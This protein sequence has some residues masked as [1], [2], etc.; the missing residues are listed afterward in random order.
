MK[1]FALT[2]LG[3]LLAISMAGCSHKDSPSTQ[4]GGD[5]TTQNAESRDQSQTSGQTSDQS[6]DNEGGKSDSSTEAKNQNTSKSSN[7]PSKPEAVIQ[8]L[9]QAVHVKFNKMAPAHVPMSS[10]MFLTG[11]TKASPYHYDVHF[12]QTSKPTPINSPALNHVDPANDLGIVSGTYYANAD[13]AAKQISIESFGANKPNV[14]LG[15]GIK[16]LSD[17]GAGHSYLTWNEG[18]WQIQIN[19]P[20]DSQYAYKGVDG[21]AQKALGKK[22]VNFLENNRLPV[23]H[24]YGKITIDTWKNDHS[25]T[26]K[27]QEEKTIYQIKNKDP[28]DAL[29]MAVLMKKY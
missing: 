15:H 24:Q 10:H 23:P 5:K 14:D 11:T 8:A 21:A 9:M 2:V 20:L 26:I 22:I 12:I 19:S 4:K 29:N 7:P 1:K 17:A 18:R 3:L 28:I 6:A 25:T 16:G 27:W 13:Q